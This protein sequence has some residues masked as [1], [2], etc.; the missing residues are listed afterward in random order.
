MKIKVSELSGAALD[1]AVARVEAVQVSFID[2]EVATPELCM[3]AL[4]D[5]YNPAYSPSTDWSQGGPLLSKYKITV[6]ADT[7]RNNRLVFWAYAGVAEDGY[8]VTEGEDHLVSSMR[9]IIAS[10]F[11][12]EIEIPEDLL[13]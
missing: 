8:P 5:V 9:A 13:S 12:E 2:G 11:G 7:G 3:T 1:W 6:G 10:M 4:G